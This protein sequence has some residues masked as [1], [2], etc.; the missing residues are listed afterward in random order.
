LLHFTHDGDV[1]EQEL[2][3]AMFKIKLKNKM[4]LWV[5]L[6]MEYTPNQSQVWQSI[7][8]AAN[9]GAGSPGKSLGY[10]KSPFLMAKS[11]VNGHFQ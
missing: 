10:G 3:S 5:C 7:F 1:N 9:F 8:H 4:C 2:V 6:K 11:T